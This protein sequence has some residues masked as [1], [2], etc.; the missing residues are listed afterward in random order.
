LLP[1]T[2][3]SPATRSGRRSLSVPGSA[4]L[5]SKNQ[6]STGTGVGRAGSP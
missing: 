2:D 1:Q 4:R 3:S 6:S 5:S